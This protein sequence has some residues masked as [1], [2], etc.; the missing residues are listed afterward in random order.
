MIN[1]WGA[2]YGVGVQAN[3]LYQRSDGGF[4]W[5]Q[6]G[7]HNDNQNNPGTGGTNL[8]SLDGSGNLLNSASKAPSQFFPAWDKSGVSAGQFHIPADIQLDRCWV[9]VLKGIANGRPYPERVIAQGTLEARTAV[10]RFP[11]L[12][13]EVGDT[14]VLIVEQ[15]ELPPIVLSAAVPKTGDLAWRDATPPLFPAIDVLPQPVAPNEPRAS[16]RVHL[17]YQGQPAPNQLPAHVCIFP[18]GQTPDYQATSL[19]GPYGASWFSAPQDVPTLDGH[20]VLRWRDGSL[21]LSS[22]S[23]GGDGP[24]SSFPFPANPMNAG[25][26]D[27]NALLFMYKDDSKDRA[28]NDIKVVTTLCHGLAGAP[29]GGRERSYTFGIAA[30]KSLPSAFHPTLIMYYDQ[31]DEQDNDALT[32]DGILA[33]CRRTANGDWTMLP[34]YLPPRFRFAVAPLDTNAGGSLL[35]ASVEEPRVEYY[36]VCW[37]PRQ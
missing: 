4:A 14:V 34:T 37:V 17:T 18:L 15:R 16:L 29:A 30:N 11:L 32:N 22:F 1:L 2:A 31:P 3:T 36:K 7:S 20:V 28:P 21:L 27:G 8:M 9:Y 19:E 12:G 13:A 26:A 25:S 5:F 23:Q 6:K 33:I 35:V 24:N 10:T